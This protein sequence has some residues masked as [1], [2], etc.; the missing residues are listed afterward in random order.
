MIDIAN[1]D[2][3]QQ[4]LLDKGYVDRTAPLDVGYCGGGVSGTVAFVH[5][6]R[7]QMIVKQALAQLKVKE[8]WLC[9]PNRMHIEMMSNDIYHKLVPDNAPA[10]YF[11]DAE[12]YI[13][14]REAAPDGCAMWKS[15]LLGGLLDCV[16]AAKVMQSLVVVHNHCSRDAQARKDF[17][18]KTIFHDLRI[19]PYITFVVGKYPAIAD[20]AQP[21]VDTLMQ[22]QITLVHGDFSPKNVM[23]DGRKIYILDFE[24]AH[25]GHPAFDLA[26]FSNHF[27][28]KSVKN[29]QWNGAYLTMLR[30]MLDRYFAEMDF[31]DGGDLEATFIRLLALLF[32]ARVDGKSPAE[33]ITEETDKALIRS[34]AF[35]MIEDD[36]R[37]R[38]E[39]LRLVYARTE[40]ARTIPA[41]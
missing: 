22:S 24:V 32:L 11:Y 18:D 10:V 29:K 41:P 34:I 5:N 7:R 12:N 16:V 20:F 40:E 23:V 4:Y 25:Y 39:M 3:L 1:R 28:L 14:G 9:D 38:E 2:V 15:D 33:Y 36:T 31:M 8:T 21:V 26:F 17:A 35:S 30:Y 13:F 27:L 6:G 19:S 37:T